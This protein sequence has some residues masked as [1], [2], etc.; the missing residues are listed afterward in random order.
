MAERQLRKTLAGLCLLLPVQ[1]HA[2]APAPEI[3]ITDTHRF[4]EIRNEIYLAQ[5]LAPVFNSN[6]LVIVN[7]DDVVLVDSHVTP[8]K[9]RDLAEAIR[10]I[11]PKPVTALINSH[12]H[13]DHAHGNQIFADISIIGHEFTYAKLAAAPLQEPTYV[14]GLKGNDATLER[15]KQQI[16]EEEDP[17]RKQELETY[18]ELFTEHVRDFDETKPVPPTVTL[19]E[20]MTLYRGGREIQIIFLGRAHTGGDVVV[21]FPQDKVVFTGDMA[22]AGPSYLGDGYVD[23]WPQT[24]ENLKA[25]DFDIFVPG[26]GAPVT[27]RGRISLVQAYYRDLWAKAAALHA[28]GISAG[29]AAEVIDLTNHTGIPIGEVG[30][31]PLA[32]QRIYQRLN[33]PD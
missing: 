22:F 11:T 1:I 18:L 6:S 21:Y 32:I 16:A 2:Q 29:A 27:D 9:A 8:Q 24:L 23:E 26:H 17:G 31:S 25:L 30:A 10:S 5:S 4:T 3:I 15:V 33:N 20:R 19:K 28:Q 7:K 12:H 14:N 13:W